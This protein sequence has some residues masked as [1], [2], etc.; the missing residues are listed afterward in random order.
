MKPV[1]NRWWSMVLSTPKKTLTSACWQRSRK[2][3]SLRLTEDETE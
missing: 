3:L 2:G 1:F